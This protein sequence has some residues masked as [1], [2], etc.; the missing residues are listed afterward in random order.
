MPTYSAGTRRSSALSFVL[1]LS[2][3]LCSFPPRCAAAEARPEYE[4]KAAFLLNFP[5]FIEWP[6]SAFERSDSPLAICIIGDDPFGGTLDQLVENEV[7]GG[8]KI[9]LQ[10]IRRPPAP[11]SCQVLFIGKSENDVRGLLA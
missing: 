3:S 6:A 5:K 2:A 1:C 7:V 4:V 10:R 8:R 9:S 11:K